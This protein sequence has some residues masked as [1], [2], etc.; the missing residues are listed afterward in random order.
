ME[1]PVFNEVQGQ[2]VVDA[3]LKGYKTYLDVRLKVK[4]EMEV[5]AGYAWTKPNYIDDA[6]SKANFPF[7]TNYTVQHAGQS[8]EY[9]EF[10]SENE[11]LGNV[12]LI[13]KGEARLKQHFPEVATKKKGYL[14]ELA[15]INNEFIENQ[16]KIEETDSNTK[17]DNIQLELIQDEEMKALS[18][19][20]SNVDHF[21]ILTHQVDNDYQMTKIQV[22]MPD[23]RRGKLLTLQ[24]LSEYIASS[25]IDFNDDKYQGL[26]DLSDIKDIE[27]F[28]ILPRVAIQKQG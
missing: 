3:I 13:I 1:Y 12:L 9:I 25:A 18:Q 17:L 27:E 22:V 10:E 24:D 16:V 26:T 14:F 5:S 11:M 6:F 8:W 4:V 19:H 7:I 28:G 21:L 23:A 2:Q 20:T 15:E